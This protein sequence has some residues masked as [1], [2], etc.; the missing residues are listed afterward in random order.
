MIKTGISYWF[1]YQIENKERFKLIKESG[2]DNVFLWWGD[3]FI[4]YDGNKKLLPGM[5]RTV[6]LNVENVH[7]PFDN[8]NCIWTQTINAEDIVKR[9]SQ[10]IID[11]SQQNIPTA[12]I[13]LTNG[14]TP[15]QPTLLGLDRIKYLVEL[16]EQ[17]GV[18]IALEN[19]RRPE[20]LQFVFLN[21][22]SSRLGFCYDSGHENCYSK[23][24]DLLSTYG[25][26]LMAL[27]LHD[28]DGTDDQHRIPG[29]GTIN[30]DSIVR[31]I[32]STSYSGAISLEVTN[33]FSKQYY[34]ISAH[35]FLMLANEKV[36]NIFL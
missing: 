33:E 17:K 2:F 30:W 4:N 6:G 15:P 8:T 31:K 25:D 1:G 20:Y 18:N 9:Y 28:N 11:C 14:D 3:E 7:A 29:E 10:C 22:Q 13:H 36:T 32:K 35:E 26:K 24:T 16:A 34:G 27:H 21:I 5:A 19:L 23:G 12:V